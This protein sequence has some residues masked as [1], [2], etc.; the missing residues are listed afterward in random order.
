MKLEDRTLGDLQK[1]ILISLN[2]YCETAKEIKRNILNKINKEVTIPALY[3][4]LDRLV[5]AELIEVSEIDIPIR[6]YRKKVRSYGITEKG[7]LRLDES[8][9]DLAKMLKM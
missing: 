3:T 6:G 8:I 1:Y 9:A 5:K 4:T 2:Q 7:Q